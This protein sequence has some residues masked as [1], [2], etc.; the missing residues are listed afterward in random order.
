[1]AVGS[2]GLPDVHLS[3]DDLNVYEELCLY[4]RSFSPQRTPPQSPSRPKQ[5]DECPVPSTSDV[6]VDRRLALIEKTLASMTESLASLA[7][8]KLQTKIQTSADD[9]N[10]EEQPATA[11]ACASMEPD[12]EADP[13]DEEGWN[14]VRSR[15]KRPRQVRGNL[16]GSHQQPTSFQAKLPIKTSS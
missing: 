11:D 13:V 16:T 4:K 9:S 14:V 10:K 3:L 15:D 6:A 2:S 5:H 7:S 12:E 8:D 1:M